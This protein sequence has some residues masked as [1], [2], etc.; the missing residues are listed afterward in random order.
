MVV[1]DRLFIWGLGRTVVERLLHI[2]G[3]AGSWPVKFEP[4]SVRMKN[5]DSVLVGRLSS[6]I[7]PF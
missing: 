7:G 4:K 1:N 2:I 5:L 3:V 6:T